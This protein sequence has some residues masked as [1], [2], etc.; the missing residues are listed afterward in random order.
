MLRMAGE[1]TQP[2]R[3]H[4][5]P[6]APDR[7]TPALSCAPPN[8]HIKKKCERTR[9]NTR[10][11]FEKKHEKTRPPTVLRFERQ[12][13]TTSPHTRVPTTIPDHP[14]APPPPSLAPPPNTPSVARCSPWIHLFQLRSPSFRTPSL[15]GTQCSAASARTQ[16]Q[17]DSSSRVPCVVALPVVLRAVLSPVIQQHPQRHAGG[18][19]SRPRRLRQAVTGCLAGR[20]RPDSSSSSVMCTGIT[21]SSRR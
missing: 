6:G 1:Y 9:E 16:P 17:T 5:D 7:L 15:P 19:V 13:K 20:S 11:S 10:M 2:P 3:P 18:N 8:T 21:F 14:I 4:S 12:A